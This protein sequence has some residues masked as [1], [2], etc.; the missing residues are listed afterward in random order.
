MSSS[1]AEIPPKVVKPVESQKDVIAKEKMK[2]VQKP[3]NVQNNMISLDA[4]TEMQTQIIP[5]I[6]KL[7]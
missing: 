7:E 1:R 2:K 3:N 4:N 6:I 5:Q